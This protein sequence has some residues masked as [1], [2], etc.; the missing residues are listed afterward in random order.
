MPGP[1]SNSISMSNRLPESVQ[2]TYNIILVKTKCMAGLQI[3]WI[4]AQMDNREDV[5]MNRVLENRVAG[6]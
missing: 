3:I 2:V 4:R 5:D 1:G 6:E